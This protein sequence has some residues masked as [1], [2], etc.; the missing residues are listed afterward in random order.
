MHALNHAEWNIIDI[1]YCY[2][3]FYGKHA[4]FDKRPQI[5]GTFTTASNFQCHHHFEHIDDQGFSGKVWMNFQK[6]VWWYFSDWLKMGFAQSPRDPYKKEFLVTTQG[7]SPCCCR[8]CS[9]IQE[10]KS[11]SFQIF[12]SG[13]QMMH[14]QFFFGVR[15]TRNV[16]FWDNVAV[17]FLGFVFV[18]CVL[19]RIVIKCNCVFR[20]F[21]LDWFLGA[22]NHRL[23]Q[24]CPT[25]MMNLKIVAYLGKKLPAP[26]VQWK[27]KLR[28]TQE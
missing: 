4:C 28:D 18:L 27:V 11:W 12:E 7:V 13:R 26:P 15:K 21:F 14:Y 5:L 23:I 3:R 6:V 22:Q 9:H 16:P 24:K 25:W 19:E 17:C 20:V 8:S 10:S 1:P 2:Y